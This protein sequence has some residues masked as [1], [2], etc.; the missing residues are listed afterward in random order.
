MIKKN[1]TKDIFLQ[2]DIYN[3][4][5]TLS[6]SLN[7]GDEVSIQKYKKFI[8]HGFLRL[9]TAQLKYIISN[10]FNKIFK[11][12]DENDNYLILQRSKYNTYSKSFENGI[13]FGFITNNDEH[14]NIKK[15]IDLLSKFNLNYEIIIVGNNKEDLSNPKVRFFSYKDNG[16]RFLV[17]KKKSLIIENANKENLCIMHDHI[18]LDKHFIEG[19]LSFGNDFHF[20]DPLRFSLKKDKEIFSS[21]NSYI[22]SLSY[23]G[24]KKPIT[25]QNYVND[26]SFINGSFILGKSELFRKCGWPNHLA[27]GELEDIHFS[28]LIFLN[29]YYILLDKKNRV[30]SNGLRIKEINKFQHLKNILKSFYS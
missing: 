16:Q 19:L 15:A 2:K 20:Y 1:I 14:Q 7:E 12:L 25:N 13:T 17:N 29:G 30:L 6:R 26:S 8:D 21:R 5:H 3:Y 4:L 11:I 10:N 23:F 28:K 9:S 22:N 24:F 18:Y 27:W